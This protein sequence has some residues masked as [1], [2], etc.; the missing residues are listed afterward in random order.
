M[1]VESDIGRVTRDVLGAITDSVVA[2]LSVILKNEMNLNDY[3]V[4]RATSIVKTTIENT[5]F[6]GVNQYV[7]IFKEISRAAETPVKVK[8][9]LFG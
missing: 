8:T 7:S 2:N 4:L 5:G 3:Q 9:G 6:N 1:S